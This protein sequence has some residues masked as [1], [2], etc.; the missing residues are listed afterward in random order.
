[1]EKPELT[2]RHYE[3]WICLVICSFI[4]YAI[5]VLGYDI[6]NMAATDQNSTSPVGKK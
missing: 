6:A 5:T 4:I 1:M 2:F 3:W